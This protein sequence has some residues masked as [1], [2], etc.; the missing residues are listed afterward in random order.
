MWKPI[1]VKTFTKRTKAAKGY[2]SGYIGKSIKS[3]YESNIINPS[4][5]NIIKA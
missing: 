4:Y 5:V 1:N 3:E 2:A